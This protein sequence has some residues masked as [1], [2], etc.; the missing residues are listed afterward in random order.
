MKIKDL[1]LSVYRIPTD[2]PEADGTIHWD[3]TTMVLVEAIAE[4][5]QRGL[6]FSYASRA[7][8]T[9]IHDLLAQVIIG[10]QV[11]DIGAAWQAMVRSVRN[12]GRPG[13]AS[14]AISAVDVALWD[15]K[16]RLLDR[17]LFK[18]LGPYRQCVPIYGSGG[19]TTYTDAEL[20]EQ[21]SGWVAAGIPRLKMKIG[22]DWGTQEGD[23][24][25]RVEVARRAIGP[26]AQLFVDA[27]GAYS[28]KQ[29][30][31]MAWKFLEYGVTYFE[32]PVSSDQL[33]QLAFIR[34][35]TRQEVA[36]GEY[37]YDPWYFRDML[38]A[39][40]VDILQADATRCLGITGW[41]EAADLAHSFA[42]PFSAHTSPTIHAQ[43]GCAAPRLEHVEYFYDHV[44]IEKMFFEG[45]PRLADGCLCP[46]PDRPGL[47]LELKTSDAEKWKVE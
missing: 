6:G 9:L 18:L 2:R 11:E 41:L 27:N 1:K 22:K 14:T 47:G 31:R 17:P 21:L 42:I 8:A 10:M 7:A 16:A 44:R 25:H 26:D 40:A 13:V 23:D 33:E 30:I 45:L 4:S 24:L 37:G 19:F 3:S 34:G 36:A 46:D 38:R 32:E 20:A 35:Q 29:A 39:G 15:L 5:G 43:A 28:A 12:L